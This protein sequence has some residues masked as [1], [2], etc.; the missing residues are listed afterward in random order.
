MT[1]SYLEKTLRS[2]AKARGVMYLKLTGIRGIPDRMLLMGG[3]VI[4]IELKKPTTGRASK[5]QKL[6]MKKLIDLGFEA[7]VVSDTAHGKGIID[8]LFL[9]N[10]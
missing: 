3:D 10:K 5:Q 8:A 6:R 7:I 9:R 2:H 1:E 4:F